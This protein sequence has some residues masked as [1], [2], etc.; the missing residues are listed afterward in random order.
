MEKKKL[1][2]EQKIMEL[3]DA[4]VKRQTGEIADNIYGSG[5]DNH[6]MGLRYAAMELGDN[7]PELFTDESFGIVHHFALSTSQVLF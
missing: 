2:Q 1:F 7:L 4:A 3:F 5:I 6:L